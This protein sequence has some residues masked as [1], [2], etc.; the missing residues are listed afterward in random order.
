MIRYEVNGGEMRITHKVYAVAVT[1]FFASTVN[2]EVYLKDE[3]EILGSWK[4]YAE[5]MTLEGQRNPVNIQWDFKKGGMLHTKAFS[6]FQFK[7]SFEASVKYSIEDGKIKKQS[8]PGREKY[9]TCQVIEKS[10]SD[11]ILKCKELYRFMSRK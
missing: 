4:V 7:E 9:E 3:S 2:A 11:M 10:S 5:A 8:A 1:V 6:S